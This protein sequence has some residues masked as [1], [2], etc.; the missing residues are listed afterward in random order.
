MKPKLS[1]FFLFLDMTIYVN[2][3]INR[4]ELHQFFYPPP[5]G[6]GDFSPARILSGVW[7]PASR[8]LVGAKTQ[9]LLVKSFWNF[10]MTIVATW[11][12]ASDFL[13]M[14]PKIK[15]AARGQL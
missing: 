2:M 13:E 1:L 5:V 11:G 4:L 15:M 7:R 12:C 14:L 8:F 6:K 9:K 10:N 3:S